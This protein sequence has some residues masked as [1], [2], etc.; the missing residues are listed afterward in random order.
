V[1]ISGATGVRWQGRGGL[2]A[3]TALGAALALSAVGCSGDGA[4]TA[5]AT[6]AIA[7]SDG[8]GKVRPDSPISVRVANG[9]LH[10][11]TVSTRGTTR[12]QGNKVEGARTVDGAG[13]R[14]RWTLDPDMGYQVTATALGRDG[15]TRTVSSSFRTAR[16]KKPI[17]A[18]AIAPYDGETV[19]VGMPIMLHFDRKVRNRAQVERA[20]EVRSSKPVE[21]AWYWYT[22]QDVIFRTKKYWPRRSKVRVIAHL[23]GVRAAKGVYGARN[24]D[25][26]FKVGDKHISVASENRHRMVV[27]KNGKKVRTMPISMGRGGTWKYIT[28]NGTHLAM[29]KAYLTI[30]DSSTTGCPPGC[31]GYY[32]QDVYW[33]IRISDSGEFVHSAPW[34]V[35]SQGNAN[36]SHGCVNARPG[37]AVWFYRFT[38][39]GDII[40]VTGTRREL[41]YDNGWG[42][43][44]KPWRKWVKGSAFK[45]SIVTAH[46]DGSVAQLTRSAPRARP[47]Q[48]GTPSPARPGPGPRAAHN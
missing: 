27:E 48:P 21:G 12:R 18:S 6:V 22:N 28:T 23:S 29:D 24:L 25:L 20:L 46:L 7:P 15:M 4:Q 26:R 42:Y 1:H 37:D 33:T 44:Q 9:K 10:N 31:P 3:G 38:R 40:K 13:W 8:N 16:V 30:M 36:V 14:S 32:R 35:G 45:R 34:S 41:E 19:G 43:W 11:V 17:A 39:R 5:D 2:A 47:T